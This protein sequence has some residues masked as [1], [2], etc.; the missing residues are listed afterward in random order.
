MK[1]ERE[2]IIFHGITYK[3]KI[4]ISVS[5]SIILKVQFIEREQK[6][7]ARCWAIEEIL[8]GWLKGANVQ[9]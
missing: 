7:V 8:K 2:R 5:I 1:S 4:A 3:W 9:L 6:M